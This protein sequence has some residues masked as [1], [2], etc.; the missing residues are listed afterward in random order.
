MNTNRSLLKAEPRSLIR[1]D[2]C[3]FVV[4]QGEDT[5]NEG[6]GIRAVV[7]RPR[8]RP[9]PSNNGAIVLELCRIVG[10]RRSR[11]SVP[12]RSPTGP[13]SAPP[14]RVRR[15]CILGCLLAVA[16]IAAAQTKEQLTAKDIANMLQSGRSERAIVL[17]L[18][19]RPVSMSDPASEKILKEAGASQELINKLKRRGAIPPL[20]QFPK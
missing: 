4:C 12:L 20:P 18:S 8:S 13:S 7:D 19:S 6:N 16:A 15:F 2:S 9:E 11:S 10:Q 17:E 5:E 3:P 1:V 14:A